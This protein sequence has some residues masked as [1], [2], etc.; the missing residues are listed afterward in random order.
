MNGPD[1][2]KQRTPS[3]E[4]NAPRQKISSTRALETGRLVLLVEDSL[5]IQTVAMAQLQ[6]LGYAVVV[7]ENGL[8]AVDAV[9]IALQNGKTYGL[10]LM[11][12]QMPEMDGYSATQAIRK[13]EQIYG[14]HS[15]IVAMT[16]HALQRDKDNS[17]EAGMDDYLSKPVQLGDLKNI[18]NR[19]LPAGV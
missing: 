9:E 8:Q 16:A 18:L 19:W 4:E 2:I 5:I 13:L 10:I 14:R 11:D 6:L 15:P 3:I 1:P 7:V 12:V 17:L